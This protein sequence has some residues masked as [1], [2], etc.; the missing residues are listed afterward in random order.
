M[1]HAQLAIG[2]ALAKSSPWK[3]QGRIIVKSSLLVN[4]AAGAAAGVLMAFAVGPALA[5]GPE[6]VAGPAA[7]TQCYVPWATDTSSSSIPPRAD[8][9]GS[10]SP[11]ATSP[12]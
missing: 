5:D 6:I 4:L 10:R 11:T 12:T 2:E 8:R 9:T 7:D 1:K 3:I